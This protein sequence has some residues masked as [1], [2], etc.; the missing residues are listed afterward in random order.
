MLLLECF[1][2]T[3]IPVVIYLLPMVSDIDEHGVTVTKQ[4]DDIADYKVVVE[5]GVVVLSNQLFMFRVYP[6]LFP[7]DAV[8][9]EMVELIGIPLVEQDM[10]PHEMKTS[11]LFFAG[12]SGCFDL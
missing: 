2:S 7:P 5:C 4:L 6:R 12:G 11:R 9:F 8:G 1:P 10:L 3:H